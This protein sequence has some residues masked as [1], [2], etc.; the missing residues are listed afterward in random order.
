MTRAALLSAL[1]NHAEALAG[2]DR[3]VAIDPL[4]VE[5]WLLRAGARR[6]AADRAGA[7]RDVESGLALAP[8][9]TRLQTLRGRLLIDA[10]RPMA[11]LA[12]LD[13]SLAAGGSGRAHTAR[14]L[15]LW[16]LGRYQESTAEWT[17][18]LRD[19]TEDSDACLGRARC[20]A[21]LGR[22]DPALADLESAV[23]WSQDRPA[24]LARAALLYVSCLTERP[25]RLSRALGLA[26]RAAIAQTRR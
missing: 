25:N 5:V 14:A 2:A 10:G 9:D 21:R 22:W 17:L 26:A 23:D 12:A 1:G 11:A 18:A 24:V 16:E 3:A 19:D 20:F 13:R 7:M 8:G 15:A 6:K 4:V